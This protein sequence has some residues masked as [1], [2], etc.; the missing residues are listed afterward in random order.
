[1]KKKGLYSVV[2]FCLLIL[3]SCLGDPATNFTI[4]N[5]CGVVVYEIGY[6]EKQIY[7]KGGDIITSDAFQ[8]VNVGDGDCILFDYSIDFSAGENTN[9]GAENGFL[10]AT[11]Y[12]NTISE[13]TKSA[14]HQTLTDTTIVEK[15]ELTLSALQSR[16]A[17]IHNKL[18]LFPEIKNHG[19]LQVDSF[20]LSYD[21]DKALSEDNVYNLYL[22]TVLLKTDAD[23]TTNTMIVPCAF[24]LQNLVKQAI[25][26]TDNETEKEIKI[27]INYVKGFN[28]DTTACVWT[29]SD[30]YSIYAS[31]PTT[32]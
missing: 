15:N 16:Y 19:V 32:N 29:S 17:F 26:T 25:G 22:R 11:I 20:S 31:N 28:K 5:A 6:P 2:A 23:Q 24:D 8:E 13:I 4:S 7:V 27:R 3:T 21:S 9:N 10:T 30:I 1:M 18:F 12:E 14:L